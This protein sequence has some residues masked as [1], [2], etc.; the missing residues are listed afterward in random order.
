MTNLTKLSHFFLVFWLLFI[1]S[2]FTFAA[3]LTFTPNAPIVEQG[4]QIT[5]SVSGTSGE[6]TWT[7]AKGQIQGT[8]MQVT[9]VAQVG[10]DVVTVMDGEGNVATVKIVIMLSNNISLENAN[11]EVFTNRSNIYALLLSED[12]KTLWVG[13]EGGLEK[14]DAQT[15][16]IQQ[17]FINTDGLPGNFV[18]ALLSDS[19][20]GLWVGTWAKGGLAHYA[21][22]QWQ[23]FNTDNSG[24]PSNLVSS[25]FPDSQGGLWVA[26]GPEWDIEKQESV[27]GG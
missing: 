18:S 9:Y 10:L 22:G 8:G 21:Q 15:G 6:V 24:L 7:V 27:G 12:G 11:W 17:V 13:T 3:D 4:K 26:T 2:A 5:L 14:R 16:E 1:H 25:L 20:G 23:V 19:Q